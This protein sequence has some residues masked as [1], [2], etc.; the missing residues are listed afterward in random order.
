MSSKLSEKTLTTYRSTINS[1]YKN[2][3]LGNKAP[4]D[5]G[6]WIKSNFTKIIEYI[7][8]MSSEF[9][10][11]NNYAILKVWCGMFD[12]EDKKLIE[13]IDKR[14]TELAE[15]VN[16]TYST[17][18]MTDKVASNWV[19]VDDMREKVAYLKAKLPDME[20]IDT[21]KE[22]MA[23]MKYLCL[24]IHIEI[25]LRNDLSDSKLVSELPKEQDDNVN[26]LV[27]KKG[28]VTLYLNNYK[29]NKQYGTKIIPFSKE[30]SKEIIKYSSVIKRMSP[31]EWFIG[32]DGEDAPITRPTYTKLLNS[33]F[34]A[35]GKNVSS[36][37]IRRA[38]VSDLY[39]VDEN[40]YKQ[41]QQLA[42]VM[43][44]GVATASL[45]Y[46]KVLPKK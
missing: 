19:G 32:K 35:D 6:S 31:H 24:L 16:K 45:V 5:D 30:L 42:N 20:A 23:L 29:T 15:A 7:D 2:I 38:V 43:G 11:K 26:Y 3:G 14:M 41:K 27:M 34:K 18:E 9:S 8:G 39:K 28:S 37:Q 40:E 44:H 25:P 13:T 10:K 1:L 46:A 17:N 12:I 22:Y 4:V 36:T 21:Y 33:I